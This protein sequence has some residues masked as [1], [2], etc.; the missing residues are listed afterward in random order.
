[1]VIKTVITLYLTAMPN[2]NF[3]DSSMMG[4]QEMPSSATQSKV[5]VKARANVPF[6]I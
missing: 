6:N 4:K 2:L 5:T 3:E 1:M